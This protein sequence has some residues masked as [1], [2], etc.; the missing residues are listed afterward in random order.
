[1]ASTRTVS[2][3]KALLDLGKKAIAAMRE[4]SVEALDV[5]GEYVDGFTAWETTWKSRRGVASILSAKD[6]DVGRRIANQHKAILR[7]AEEM[8]ANL[9]ESLRGLRVKERGL[10]AY[11]G[12]LPQRISTMRG[13]KG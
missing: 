2:E 12:Q 3:S 11:I 7:L 6:Q 9:D 8:K 5:L 4:N 1:M 13:R 10:K